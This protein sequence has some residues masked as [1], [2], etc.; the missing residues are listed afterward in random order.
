MR[1]DIAKCVDVGT[2]NVRVMAHVEFVVGHRRPVTRRTA[3][4][5]QRRTT[6]RRVV[7]ADQLIVAI[8][9]QRFDDIQPRFDGIAQT[10]AH[11]RDIDRAGW[12]GRQWWR[13]AN[14][15]FLLIVG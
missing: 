13:T 7:V 5:T 8:P 4:R 3:T 12:S 1:L 11:R 9:A 2:G 10:R 14:D 6:I 15:R